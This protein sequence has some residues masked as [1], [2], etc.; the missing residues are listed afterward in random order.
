[1]KNLAALNNVELFYD[2]QIKALDMSSFKNK[3]ILTD[4]E[5]TLD[6]AIDSFIVGF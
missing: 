1:M 6:N 2:K 3:L 5:Y 4:N